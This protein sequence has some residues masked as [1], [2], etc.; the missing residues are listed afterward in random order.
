MVRE[1][2][3]RLARRGLPLLDHELQQRWRGHQIVTGGLDAG[4]GSLQLARLGRIVALE[5]HRGDCP[6]LFAWGPSERVFGRFRGYFTMHITVDVGE[7][8]T[9]V[10]RTSS[11][12]FRTT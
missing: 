8:A 10:S 4:L 12:T 7:R 6:A 1:L 3:R 9:D 2:R 5:G 11:R